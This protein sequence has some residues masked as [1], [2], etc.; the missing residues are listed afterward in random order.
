M[1]DEKRR[2]PMCF[3]S[4]CRKEDL[5]PNIALRQAIEHFLESQNLSCGLE[6]PFN[7]YVPGVKLV[8]HIS[9]CHLQ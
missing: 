9:P 8:Y 7:Q 6:N 1:L 4:K 2:C 3:S 5:L